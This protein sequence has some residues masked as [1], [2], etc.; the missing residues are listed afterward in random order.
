MG[1]SLRYVKQRALDMRADESNQHLIRTCWVRYAE[2]PGLHR[3]WAPGELQEYEDRIQ[4]E[5][6][7]GQ[8]SGSGL[9]RETHEGG[10]DLKAIE[11]EEEEDTMAKERVT[12]TYRI[13]KRR[14]RP[15]DR[16]KMCKP[17]RLWSAVTR[18]TKH[19]MSQ[20]CE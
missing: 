1:R 5:M 15:A 17:W 7:N 18:Y 19:Q 14:V 13:P 10:R 6:T 4:R 8:A 12:V 20:I 3:W 2:R 11:E 16:Q 9:K